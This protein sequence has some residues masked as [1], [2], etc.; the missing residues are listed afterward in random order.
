MQN[1]AV[2]LQAQDFQGMQ[3]D[4]NRNKTHLEAEMGMENVSIGGYL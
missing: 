1:N 3:L 4:Q 2:P